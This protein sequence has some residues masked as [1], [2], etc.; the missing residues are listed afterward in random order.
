MMM[1]GVQPEWS[2]WSLQPDI[3]KCRVRGGMLHV[4]YVAR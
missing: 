3:G 1:D 2:L 4:H